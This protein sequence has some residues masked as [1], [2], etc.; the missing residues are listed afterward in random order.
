MHFS[1]RFTVGSKRYEGLVLL[2]D[3]STGKSTTLLSDWMTSYFMG[4]FFGCHP[5]LKFYTLTL[6]EHRRSGTLQPTYVVVFTRVQSG[7]LLS[8]LVGCLNI[9]YY[10]TKFG[11]KTLPT[12]VSFSVDDISDIHRV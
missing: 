11:E 9:L 6:S 2:Q 5:W 12:N 4:F 8:K 3:V 1:V 10:L 7:Y